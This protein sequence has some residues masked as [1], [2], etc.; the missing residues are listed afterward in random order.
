MDP[1]GDRVEKRYRV[2]WSDWGAPWSRMWGDSTYCLE[3]PVPEEVPVS[4]RCRISGDSEPQKGVGETLERYRGALAHL[5]PL[6][7]CCVF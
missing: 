4:S 3:L 5:C 2:D 7:K 6:K 1:D